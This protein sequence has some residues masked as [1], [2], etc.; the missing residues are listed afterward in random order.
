MVTLSS[1][2]RPL[3][4][5][6]QRQLLTHARNHRITPV[7]RCN[8]TACS[9]KY[10]LSQ[11]KCTTCIRWRCTDGVFHCGSL[12]VVIC[13]TRMGSSAK[14]GLEFSSSLDLGQTWLMIESCGETGCRLQVFQIPNIIDPHGVCV[15]PFHLQRSLCEVTCWLC[16]VFRFQ[17]HIFIVVGLSLPPSHPRYSY[18]TTQETFPNVLK[19]Y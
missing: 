16:Q 1:I 3:A 5:Q 10:V 2:I 19:L 6:F 17:K 9:S 18:L 11:S 4:S 14:L 8:L 15:M 12:F 7:R 13:K